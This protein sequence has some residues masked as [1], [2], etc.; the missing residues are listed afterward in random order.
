MNS[1]DSAVE[2]KIGFIGAGRMATALARGFLQQGILTPGQ[3]LACDVSAE[4]RENFRLN[5][6]TE[7]ETQTEPVIRQADLLFIAVKPQVLDEV[8][9]QIAREAND[10]QVVVS[11]L[12]GVTLA[13]LHTLLGQNRKIVRVMPNTPCLVGAGATAMTCGENI[14]PEEQEFVRKLLATVGVCVD[15]PERLMD[16]VTGLSG[17]GPAYVFQILEAMS[18]GGVLMGL[19]RET[20]TTLAAQ[21]LLGSAQMYLQT[22]AHPGVLKDAVTSP[23]GT[24]IAGIAALEKGGLRSSLIEAITAA[25]QRSQELG[26]G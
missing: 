17:S 18:D 15:V 13:R 8:A 11:I 10:G 16:A 1:A 24:T 3:L 23:G 2:K 19:P 4:A 20:A 21:T 5:T 6:Q 7:C 22:Q 25:T 26:R 14:T 12:A 9:P